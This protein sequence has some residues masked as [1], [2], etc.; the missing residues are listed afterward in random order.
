MMKKPL[1][2]LTLLS[3]VGFGIFMFVKMYNNN[4]TNKKSET[5][6]QIVRGLNGKD[7]SIKKPVERVVTIP[8]PSASMFISVDGKTDR[9]FG[10][11]ESSK[12]ALLQGVLG[13]FYPKAKDIAS[14]ITTE[15]F[16]PNIE[17]IMSLRPDV[18]VQWE[19]MEKTFTAMENAGLKVAAFV[20]YNNEEL[21]HKNLRLVAK[22]LNKEEKQEKL[23]EWRKNTKNAVREKTASLSSQNNIQK[24]VWINRYQ[25]GMTVAGANTYVGFFFG[26]AGGE[27]YPRDN[28]KWGNK[29]DMEQLLQWNPDIIIIGNFDPLVPQDV[30]DDVKL[31]QL[32]AVKNR[33]V[34]KMPLG[35]YRWAPASQES[36]L[37]WMWSY[38]IVNFAEVTGKDGF[39][40]RKEI[41][42]AYQF[43]YGKMPTDDQIDTVLHMNLNSISSHYGQFAR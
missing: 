4:T 27:L 10:I 6:E 39:D 29:I 15:G 21:V 11:H 41:R 26:M 43:I 30:Y 28:E 19:T 37:A 3:I 18:V 1:L 25:K 31:E 12:E 40:I 23:I 17:N 22:I 7:V 24:I 33:R 42:D 8:M 14:N 38:N 32:K 2:F 20:K 35:G 36:P 9:L 34:Y 13:D 16:T 5:G